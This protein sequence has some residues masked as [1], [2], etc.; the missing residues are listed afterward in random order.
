MSMFGAKKIHP[1]PFSHCTRVITTFDRIYD[2]D[3]AN[4]QIIDRIDLS[5]VF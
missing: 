4:V 3:I 2:L 1:H 5:I